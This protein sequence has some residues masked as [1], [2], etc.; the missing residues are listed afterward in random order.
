MKITKEIKTAILVI[1]SLL[2]FIWGYSFLKGRDLLSNYRTFYAHYDN[3]EGLVTSAPVT[4]NGVTI[5]KVEKIEFLDNLG[6]IQVEMQIQSDFPISK[7]SVAA[8][9]EPGLIAGKQVQIIPNYQDKT[10]AQS[11]DVLASKS[12]PGLT[13]LLGEK[14][15]P[16]QQDLT[17]V[18]HN[19]DALLANVNE[20]LDKDSKA[21]LRQ[22]I[23]EMRMTM[24][25]FHKA[26]G[27]LNGILDSNKGKIDNVVTNFNKISKDFAQISDS[28]NKADLGKTA[29]KLQVTLENVDRIIAGIE[30]GK[31]TMGKLM[32]DET[33]Y[34]ELSSASNE[35]ELLLQDVRLNPT[36]YV[37]ISLFGKK[38]KPYVAPVNDSLKK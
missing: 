31:G 23:A 28:L 7:S 24:Q 9:Y 25:E 26:S 22:A 32:K 36:R 37:N 4:I 17:K 11:G 10:M 33:L 14:L 27:S 30:S 38:N 29:Q 15:E 5:G 35:L 2:L 34:K 6:K 19:A 8:L 3:V 12:I 1:S 18:L 13:G 20:V 21:N 16:L